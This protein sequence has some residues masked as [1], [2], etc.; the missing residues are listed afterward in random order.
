MTSQVKFIFAYLYEGEYVP[1]TIYDSYQEA[2]SDTEYDDIKKGK[3]QIWEYPS[4]K[5]FKIEPDRE[6][7]KKD[8]WSAPGESLWMPRLVQ[9]EVDKKKV[10]EACDRLSNPSKQA[11][12][13][14]R[15]QR[16]LRKSR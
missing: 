2:L 9:V 3:Y 8:F 11:S 5:I 14:T 13:F 1:E 15:L 10:A 6:V 4:G 12:F 7:N 16:R